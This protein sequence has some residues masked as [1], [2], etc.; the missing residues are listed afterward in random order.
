MKSKENIVFLGMI[1][2]GKTSIGKLI[3]KK[4]NTEFFDVDLKI[5]FKLGMKIS[6]IFALKGENFFRK[7]EEMITLEGLKK[8]NIVIALG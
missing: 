7:Q 8:K 3:S 5:E 6:K 4:L 2:S 1:G